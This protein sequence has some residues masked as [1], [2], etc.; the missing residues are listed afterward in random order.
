MPIDVEP[1]TDLLLGAAY[2]DKRIE[3]RE[4]DRIRA[5][6][7]KILGTDTL[8]EAYEAR[9]RA[10]NPAKF[11][12]KAAAAPYADRSAA[13]KRKL[14]EL[15]ASVSDA[16]GELDLAESDYLVAVAQGLGMKEAEYEDL[17][18]TLLDEDDF[19]H[20]FDVFEDDAPSKP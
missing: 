18:I 2:A 7:S 10:F 12:P 20:F 9:L 17:T 15:I 19:E 8:P 1:L 5:I 13:D 11:D 16:D 4:L 14:L 3:G 6:L